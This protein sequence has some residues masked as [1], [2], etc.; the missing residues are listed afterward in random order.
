LIC[1]YIMPDAQHTQMSLRGAWWSASHRLC[2]ST[3]PS[4][5]CTAPTQPQSRRR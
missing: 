2:G 3:R 4:P 1:R 5:S